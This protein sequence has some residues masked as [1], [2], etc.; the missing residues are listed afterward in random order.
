MHQPSNRW[1]AGWGGGGGERKCFKCKFAFRTT[2][3]HHP[4]SPRK[5]F[6]PQLISNSRCHVV[7]SHCCRLPRPSGIARRLPGARNCASTQRG[8]ACAVSIGLCAAGGCR[9]SPRH[10]AGSS[11]ARVQLHLHR[12]LQRGHCWSHRR[13]P[14]CVSCLSSTTHRCGC[15]GGGCRQ[16]APHRNLFADLGPWELRCRCQDAFARNLLCAPGCKS[17]LSLVGA[18]WQCPQ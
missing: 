3:D 15:R 9:P 11:A 16:L 14:L 10:G 1:A 18:A 17:S 5:L 4:S 6:N 7:E 8:C 2:R 13:Y 12:G